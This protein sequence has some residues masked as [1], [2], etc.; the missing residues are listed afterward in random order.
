MMIIGQKTYF[1]GP[2]IFK[3]TQPNCRKILEPPH[4]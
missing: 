2:T 4:P 3:I 1:L